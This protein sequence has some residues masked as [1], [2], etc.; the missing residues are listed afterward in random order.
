[1]NKKDWNNIYIHGDDINT[2]LI[3]RW[4][5]NSYKIVSKINPLQ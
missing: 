5:Y 2:K 3:K 4:I 1:M